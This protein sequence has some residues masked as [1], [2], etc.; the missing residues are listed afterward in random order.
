M[1]NTHFLYLMLSQTNT[2]IGK[3]IRLFSH[4]NFN[5]VSLSLDPTFRNWV[6]FARYVQDVPL[7]GGFVT[8]SAERFLDMEGPIPVKIYRMELSQERYLKLKDLFSRANSESG[9][10]YN[11]L[12]LFAAAFGCRYPIQGAYTCLDFAGVI[13]GTHFQ[14]IRMLEHTLQAPIIYQG[15][16]KALL[17]DN[18]RREDSYFDHRGFWRGS[19]DTAVHFSKLFYRAFT[20][21]MSRDPILSALQE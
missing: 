11:T 21:S 16:L 3:T 4:Y 17:S 20:G 19:K 6:S 1:K 12:S 7:A 15:D 13:L 10:I 2:R 18:G 14:S 5:H 9:L 8:E